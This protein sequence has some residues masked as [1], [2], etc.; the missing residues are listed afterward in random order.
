M[1]KWTVTVS[2]KASITRT[3]EAAT[4]DEAIGELEDMLD[5]E[6]VMFEDY[7]DRESQATETK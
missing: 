3:I 4:E 5:N 2:E 1:R 7:G 6:E